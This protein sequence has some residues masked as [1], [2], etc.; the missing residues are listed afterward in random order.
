MQSDSASQPLGM[1]VSI[2]LKEKGL[3]AGTEIDHVIERDVFYSSDANLIS[4]RFLLYLRHIATAAS[5][6]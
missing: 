4:S 6:F 1:A 3:H 5:P 2:F